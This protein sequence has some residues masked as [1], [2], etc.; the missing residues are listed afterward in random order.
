MERLIKPK[1]S[2]WCTGYL[3]PYNR[4]QIR[5]KPFS[6][7]DEIF[8]DKMLRPQPNDYIFRL[9]KRGEYF[10]YYRYSDD[11]KWLRRKEVMEYDQ[12]IIYKNLKYIQ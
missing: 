5:Y 3:I 8:A 6:K 1:I 9:T 12:N 7:V 4:P 11:H 10:I 2:Y